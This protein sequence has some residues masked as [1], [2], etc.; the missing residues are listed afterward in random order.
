MYWKPHVSVEVEW[1]STFTFTRDFP[2]I[3]SI[4]FTRI[5]FTFENK[6]EIA[7]KHKSWTSLNFTFKRNASKTYMRIHAHKNYATVEIKRIDYHGP[8]ILEGFV[9]DEQFSPH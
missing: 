7:R 6:K 8:G 5:K 1:G 2:Y 9:W 4:L 3:A